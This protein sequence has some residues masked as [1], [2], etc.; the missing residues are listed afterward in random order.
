[1]VGGMEEQRQVEYS[2]PMPA[3][4]QTPIILASDHGNS[5]II[6]MSRQGGQIKKLSQGQFGISRNILKDPIASK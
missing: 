1:M 3:I 4:D 6:S 2:S 5:I